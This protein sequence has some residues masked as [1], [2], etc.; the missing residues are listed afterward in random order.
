MLDH[1]RALRGSVNSLTLLSHL[2]ERYP[3]R[4]KVRDCIWKYHCLFKKVLMKSVHGPS[5]RSW[6]IPCR[7]VGPLI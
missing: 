2:R 5:P 7:V 1:S 3:S 6:R 4:V